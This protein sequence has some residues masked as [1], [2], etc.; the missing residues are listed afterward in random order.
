MLN[1]RIPNGAREIIE[2]L[3]ANGYKAYVVGGC[4]RD[5]LLGKA[6]HDWDI[7]TSA[8]PEEME[9]CVPGKIV[10]TGIQHGTIT[11]VMPDGQYE[12]TTF[13]VDGSYSDSRHPDSVE[14]VRDVT[15][16]L[17]RRDFTVNA[18]AY[19]EGEGLIDPFSGRRHLAD[20]EIRCVGSPD[21]RFEEDALR[22][23][24]ALRFAS[25]YDFHIE[26]ETAASIHRHAGLLSRVSAE[27]ISVELCR[28][29][30]GPAV[31]PILLD[32]SDVIAVIIP[33]MAP[34]IGFDQNNRYHQYT[35]YDHIAHAVANYT[36]DDTVVKLTLLLHDIGKPQCYTEDEKGGHFHGHGVPS[37]ELARAALER[38]RFDNKTRDAVTELVLLHD[39]YI[40][41]THK[42]VKRVLNRLG[43]EDRFR[44][45]LAIRRADILAH[46]KDTQAER[47]EKNELLSQ[48]LE[49]VLEQKQCFS[50]KDLRINGR[51]IMS[52]GV[53]EGR[54][55]GE[56]LRQLLGA[57]ING[58]LENDAEGLYAAAQR[59]VLF[60]GWDDEDA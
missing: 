46:A 23:L 1:I 9:A 31:L 52:L 21:A 43:G 50:L 26:D 58:E 55:V 54:R 4:V 17:A 16:D 37:S 33:E 39:M 24:R 22:V 56:V 20:R 11:S 59:I 6:P 42:A 38:L 57:V 51:D 45:L 5:S 30:Q 40:A 49:E 29:L 25:T 48:L 35:V 60:G 15:Q 13:R 32:Y 27:R 8:K 7:C 53:P 19:N 2:S 44:Q 34:C 47:L 12:I 18:M 3:E 28:L 36:G 14:F 41:P 10:E